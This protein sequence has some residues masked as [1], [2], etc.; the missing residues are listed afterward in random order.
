[1]LQKWTCFRCEFGGMYDTEYGI[2]LLVYI[3]RRWPRLD[4]EREPSLS[5]TRTCTTVATGQIGEINGPFSVVDKIIRC[6]WR[7]AKTF[8]S[9]QQV[10]MGPWRH[11][12][13]LTLGLK[14]TQRETY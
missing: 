14:K 13:S 7:A 9:F 2:T 6:A 11:T 8:L 5:S 4:V 12:G 3:R 1:M 10:N